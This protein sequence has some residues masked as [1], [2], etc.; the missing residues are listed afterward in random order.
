MTRR[1]RNPVMAAPL[2]KPEGGLRATI[3]DFR[4]RNLRKPWMPACAVMTGR[5]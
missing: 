2:V 1:H 4:G 5:C 3:H